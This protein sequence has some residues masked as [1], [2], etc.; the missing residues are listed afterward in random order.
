MIKIE[1]VDSIEDEK[2]VVRYGDLEP[3]MCFVPACNP[4][5]EVPYMKTHKGNLDL[6][7]ASHVLDN[8]PY[9][10]GADVEVIPVDAK[11][12]WA[13]RGGEEKRRSYE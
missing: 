4:H 9:V 8:H 1:Q 7:D 13:H 6:R 11:L 5:R 2:K 10:F 3:R 12:I